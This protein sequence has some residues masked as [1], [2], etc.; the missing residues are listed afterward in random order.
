MRLDLGKLERFWIA[1]LGRILEGRW[2]DDSQDHVKILPKSC[3][4]HSK[5]FSNLNAFSKLS[6]NLVETFPNV[7]IN[8]WKCRETNSGKSQNT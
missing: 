1:D 4:N 5:S 8:F 3:E 2:E 7:E 6:E